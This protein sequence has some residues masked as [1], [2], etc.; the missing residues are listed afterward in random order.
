[1]NV[2]AIVP[3]LTGLVAVGVNVT[4]IVEPTLAQP[5][6]PLLRVLFH[7]DRVPVPVTVPVLPLLL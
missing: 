4:G 3:A 2:M 6:L 5:P 1:M 7:H